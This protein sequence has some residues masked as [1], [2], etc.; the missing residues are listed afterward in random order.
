[1]YAARELSQQSEKLRGFV[2]EFLHD[3]HAAQTR[4][5]LVDRDTNIRAVATVG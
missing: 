3:V 2:N 5:L 1:V 4:G